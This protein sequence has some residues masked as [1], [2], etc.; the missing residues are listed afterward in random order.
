VDNEFEMTGNAFW[1][2]ILSFSKCPPTNDR[3]KRREN[4]PLAD[5]EIELEIIFFDMREQDAVPVLEVDSQDPEGEVTG[6]TTV[7]DEVL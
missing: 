1:E 2:H 7:E 5:H 3:E 6:A 4:V